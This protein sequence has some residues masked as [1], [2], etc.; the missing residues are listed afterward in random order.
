MKT[1]LT[2]SLEIEVIEKAKI[3]AKERFTHLSEIVER[4]YKNLTS[5]RHSDY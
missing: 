2:L 4:Y 1:K 5:K 3:Y